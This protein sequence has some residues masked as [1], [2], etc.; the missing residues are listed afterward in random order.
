LLQT[1]SWFPR[2]TTDLH[3]GP[4]HADR[5]ESQ[6]FEVVALALQSLV[7]AEIAADLLG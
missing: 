2:T 7:A 4:D 5:K 6:L 1:A 3:P